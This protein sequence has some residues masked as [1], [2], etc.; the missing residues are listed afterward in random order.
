MTFKS[1]KSSKQM[2]SRNAEERD[3]IQHPE[4]KKDGWEI[5]G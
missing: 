1:E 4:I 5:S 3:K 2:K